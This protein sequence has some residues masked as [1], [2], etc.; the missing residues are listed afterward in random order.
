MI[1]QR[2][3]PIIPREG[4]PAT[5]AG[6]N[7]RMRPVTPPEMFPA[8]L[9]GLNVR[10]APVTPPESYP[11]TLGELP[12]GL[13]TIDAMRILAIAIGILSH[14][15]LDTGPAILASAIAPFWAR[16]WK[17]L[18]SSGWDQRALG[19]SIAAI[20]AGLISEKLL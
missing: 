2:G 3:T 8:T 6:L 10:M 5:L 19:D 20:L 9:A 13:L 11:A 15:M 12:S 16:A 4:F 18:M 7:R 1:G 14:K 17:E